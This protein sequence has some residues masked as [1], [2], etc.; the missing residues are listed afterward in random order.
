V[1]FTNLSRREETGA[2]ITGREIK[3]IPATDPIICPHRCKP[4]THGGENA[5]NGLL[6][7]AVNSRSRVVRP[8]LRK[9]KVNAH[10]RSAVMGTMREGFTNLL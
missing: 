10:V 5:R 4:G 9:L 6:P 7:A 1:Q 2:A 3:V 8:M